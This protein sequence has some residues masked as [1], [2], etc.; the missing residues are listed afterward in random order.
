MYREAIRRLTST[1]SL[2]CVTIAL[3]IRDSQKFRK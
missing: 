1:K 2:G 3:R